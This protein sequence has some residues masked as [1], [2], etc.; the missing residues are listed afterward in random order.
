MGKVVILKVGSGSFE[1]GFD[2]LLQIKTDDN[3]LLAELEGQLPPNPGLEGSYV[4]WQT[5][6][7][8]LKAASQSSRRLNTATEEAW[9]IDESFQSNSSTVDDFSRCQRLV[10]DVEK[11]MKQWLQSSTPKWQ[12]IRE[13]LGAEFA[14]GEEEIRLVI[15]TKNPRL[16]KL[17]WHVWDLLE[18]Y[19]IGLGYTLPGFSANFTASQRSTRSNK[20]RILAVLGDKRNLNLQPDQEAICKLKGAEVTFLHQPRSTQFIK[21]LRQ[22]KGWDIL[23]FAGHSKTEEKTGRIYLSE[24]ESLRLDEFKN[25][26]K[27]AI[28]NGLK[29][30]V[31][32]S[33]DGLGLAQELIQ[34]QIPVT[35]VMQESV[36]DL[37]AQSFL[38][39]FLI[40]YSTGEP[41]YAAVH[42]AQK[43]LE[44]F[45]ELPGATWLPLIFQN[46]AD[47]PP[48]WQDL[49]LKK[50]GVQ[51]IEDS[52]ISEAKI[53]K[54][55]KQRR[56]FIRIIMAV[57]AS[58]IAA[59]SMI[60]LRDFGQLELLELKTFDHF[61]RSRPAETLDSK[62]LI[63]DID[64]NDVNAQVR[65]ANEGKHKSISDGYLTQLVEKLAALEPRVIGLTLYRDYQLKPEYKTLISRFKDDDRFISQCDIGEN[66]S[67]TGRAA[68]PHA[69]QGANWKHRIG[70][71][72]QVLDR[73]RTIRRQLMSLEP[74]ED[75]QISPCQSEL[76]FNLLVALRYLSDEKILPAEIYQERRN[77]ELGNVKLNPL[78]LNS[79]GYDQLLD[80]DKTQLLLNYRATKS[81]VAPRTTMTEVLQGTI[82]PALVKD[83]IVLIGTSVPEFE[84]IYSTPYGE[85][86]EV[87]LQGHMISQLVSAV[88]DGRQ[89][90]TW[91]PDWQENIWVLAWA[92]IGG[93]LARWFRPAIAVGAAIP[94]LW[95]LHRYCYILLIEQGLWVP[96][97][98]PAL[99]L[100]TALIATTLIYRV[101]KV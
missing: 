35:I 99:A 32:N 96:F 91:W 36:P 80:I 52:D 69:V 63:V 45:Q 78:T 38:K 75:M 87:F 70:F 33:C 76:S 18:E 24:Q 62:I 28:N 79:G 72:D 59:F 90:L 41:L 44:D 56:R 46:L 16:W 101:L 94:I 64:R 39:E 77:F 50:S 48:S 8:R 14:K 73:D 57:F 82:D 95:I 29:I 97:V 54:T 26:L 21:T 47:I 98:P 27:E 51:E 85:M 20:V 61:M 58:L 49:R 7:R 17:P 43:R 100:G 4:S 74:P 19:H 68:S 40:E 30:A 23:F 55:S 9:E 11:R 53:L 5:R 15:Q 71:S 22:Q 65:P 2:V 13:R 37:V 89:L 1:Q 93:L 34:W 83:K 42:K 92:L 12:C 25:T 66:L 88:T 10:R 60:F 31:F 86:S 84:T 6:F 81:E 3:R 67:N